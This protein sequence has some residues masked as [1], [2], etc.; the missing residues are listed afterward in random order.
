MS[1]QASKLRQ[2]VAGR[3]GTDLAEPGAR[4]LAVVS[5]KGGVGKT[6][7]AA[8]LAILLGRAGKR[9]ILLDADFGLANIDVLFDVEPTP[10][11]SHVLRGEKEIL[12]CLVSVADHVKFLPGIRGLARLANL[13]EGDRDL[14]LDRFHA[15]ESE[16]DFVILDTDSGVGDNVLQLA[17]MAHEVMIVTQPELTAMNDAYACVKLLARIETV[18]QIGVVVNMASHRMEA[19]KVAEGLIG[20]TRKFLG[21]EPE[22]W[23]YV[24]KDAH[25]PV[26]VG[27]CR[28][29]VLEYPRCHASM[30]LGRIANRLLG[31]TTLEP[32][33]GIIE[34]LSSW[35]R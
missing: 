35:F 9:V 30:G 6:N 16:A 34:R 1:D 10:N 27:R 18:G 32:E 8:N 13:G 33:A 15:L 20:I 7:L 28:P 29:F 14:L 4:F 19:E 5:G 12:D 21:I 31:E 26:S 17:A 22:F 3:E 11:L 23:G 24:L 2:M 25:V